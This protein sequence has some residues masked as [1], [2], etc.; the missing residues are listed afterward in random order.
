MYVNCYSS[1]SLLSRPYTARFYLRFS[2]MCHH[3]MKPD[4]LKNHSIEYRI[5]KP[6]SDHLHDFTLEPGNM[7]QQ[8]N[9][10][11]LFNNL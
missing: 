3:A 2:T 6:L 8:Q 7:Y 9:L 10:L 1:L 4:I 11:I 5:I